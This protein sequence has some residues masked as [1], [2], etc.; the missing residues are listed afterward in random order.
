MIRALILAVLIYLALIAQDFLPAVPFLGGSHVLVVP[1]LFVYAAL[2]LPFP[3]TLGFALYTGLLSDLTFLHATGDQVEIGL[4]W[5]M[6][7]YVFLGTALRLLQP[8]APGGRWEIHCLAS[9]LA[10]SLLL[11]V[12]YLMVCLRRESFLLDGTILWQV[13]GPGLAALML[14][15]PAYFFLRLFPG[16]PW[17]QPDRPGLTS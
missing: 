17:S 14:A 12:Q 1:L 13:F 16:R 15:P 2:W 6:L 7:F 9:G 8:L 4:G 11:L 5:S 10:T 3:G